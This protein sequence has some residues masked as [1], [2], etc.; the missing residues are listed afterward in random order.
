[1]IL[2][3]Y[4]NI[5]SSVLILWLFSCRS[6]TS[7][8]LM[9]V[10]IT[11]ALD[12]IS[13]HSVYCC[14]YLVTTV[15]YMCVWYLRNSAQ[16]STRNSA[17]DSGSAFPFTWS[18]VLQGWVRYTD[19]QSKQ[20]MPS[21]SSSDMHWGSVVLHW[22]HFQSPCVLNRIHEACVQGDITSV[23]SGG[24]NKHLIKLRYSTTELRISPDP[25][26]INKCIVLQ[27]YNIIYSVLMAEEALL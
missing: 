8:N 7:G 2:T 26:D 24:F 17:L 12:V 11:L 1:M 25:G 22:V 16:A 14:S 19:A 18:P 23:F 13:T 6:R 15:I 10:V 5:K 27:N 3:N 20:S 21:I 4:C 9:T